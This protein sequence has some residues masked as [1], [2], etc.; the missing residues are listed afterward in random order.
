LK[1]L[2][3]ELSS[4]RDAIERL[5]REFQLTSRITNEHV[6]RTYDFGELRGASYITMDLVD[7]RN[8][9]EILKQGGRLDP[10][11]A[12]RFAIQIATALD[13]A[14]AAGVI[15]RDLKPGNIL[16][17]EKDHVFVADFGLAKCLEEDASLLT[18]GHMPGTPQYMSPEQCFGITLDQRTDIFSLG[19]V[20]YE[21]VTGEP[22]FSR[23]RTPGGG[24]G[25]THDRGERLPIKSTRNLGG[26]IAF[27][28]PMSQI[29]S[30]G[31]LSDH[32][33]CAGR[34]AVSRP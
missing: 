14:H 17:G 10:A 3:P 5:K 11:T 15:H 20:L 12:T 30:G 21:M 25:R 27:D 23:P 8:L 2:H 31:T 22:S 29:V 16:I 7:G 6:V 1:L 32:E 28:R 33:G 9:R 24:A 34:P 18:R 19:V 4:D 13:A 26:P